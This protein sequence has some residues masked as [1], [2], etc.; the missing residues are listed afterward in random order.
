MATLFVAGLG[1]LVKTGYSEVLWSQ[2]LRQGSQY[3][4]PSSQMRMS[5]CD[6][7]RQQNLSHSH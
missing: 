3:M 7:H 2:A 4:R 6:W 1:G 5:S